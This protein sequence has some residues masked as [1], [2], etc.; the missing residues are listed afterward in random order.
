MIENIKNG[1]LKIINDVEYRAKL[2]KNGRE[3]QKR[4]QAT[5][6]ARQY[7]EIYRALVKH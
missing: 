3:N 6:I 7:S 2:I 1:F 5:E 4:F